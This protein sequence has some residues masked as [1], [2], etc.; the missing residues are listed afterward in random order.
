MMDILVILMLS[1]LLFCCVASVVYLVKMEWALAIFFAA[2]VVLVVVAVTVEH[3]RAQ[4]IRDARQQAIER[5]DIPPGPNV[6]E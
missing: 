2:P 5:G 6:G 4:A 1:G 3:F